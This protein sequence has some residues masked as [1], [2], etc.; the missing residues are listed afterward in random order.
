M[1]FG[2]VLE[3]F[4]SNA[5][6]RKCCKRPKNGSNNTFATIIFQLNVVAL[7]SVAIA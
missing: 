3:H 4:R 6:P 1:M 2:S 7:V 5:T